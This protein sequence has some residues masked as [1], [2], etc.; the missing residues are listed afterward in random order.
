MKGIVFSFKNN[1]KKRDNFPK[2]S[3]YSIRNRGDFNLK[4]FF[5]KL[6]SIKL[7][8]AKITKIIGSSKI[9]ANVKSSFIK[10]VI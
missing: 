8:F 4:Y 6:L 5:K 10:S 9:R 1:I 7:I 2:N 3:G